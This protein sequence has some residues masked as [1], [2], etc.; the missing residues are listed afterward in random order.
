MGHIIQ[1]NLVS[2]G[3]MP[4]PFGAVE[5][6]LRT[7]DARGSQMLSHDPFDR[8]SFGAD[9]SAMRNSQLSLNM[10]VARTKEEAWEA[11]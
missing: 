4:K 8:L 2:L 3:G 5:L 9:R 1:H 10:E 7:S 6:R 11:A